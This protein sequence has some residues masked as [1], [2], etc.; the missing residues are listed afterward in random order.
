M[1]Q[2]GTELKVLPLLATPNEAKRGHSEATLVH[3]V[4]VS[5]VPNEAM[6]ALFSASL[7]GVNRAKQG[8]IGPGFTPPQ[9]SERINLLIPQR[10]SVLC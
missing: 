10:A 3:R 1:E 9:H 5:G 4:R 6:V 2:N 8:Q 7:P